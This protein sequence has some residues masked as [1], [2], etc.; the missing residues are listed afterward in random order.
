MA[1]TSQQP[2]MTKKPKQEHNKN[3]ITAVVVA[4]AATV[5]V[6]VLLLVNRVL[7]W[8]K[9]IWYQKIILILILVLI[10]ACIGFVYKG[11]TSWSE[12]TGFGEYTTHRHTENTEFQ[13]GKTLWDWLQLLI[14]PIMLAAVVFLFNYEQDQINS[15]TNALQEQ[16]NAKMADAQH[17][18]DLQI[19]KDQQQ[20][21][22]L[23]GY[24]DHMSD[25]LLMDKLRESKQGDEVRQVAKARTLA[26]LRSL[27]PVRKGILLRFLYEA[28]L[29]YANNPIIDL[30]L[31]DLTNIALDGAQLPN[32]D[33]NGADLNGAQLS[34][35]N[36]SNSDLRNTNFTNAELNN[37]NLNY[38]LLNNAILNNA[39]L[40]EISLIH[41]NL[42]KT[43]LV[44][45]SLDY[46]ILTS[47]TLYRAD[48]FD[49]ILSDANLSQA[50]L[51]YSNL[52]SSHLDYAVLKQAHIGYADL[53]YATLTNAILIGADLNHADLNHT[54]LD[55]ANLSSV[56][57][58]NADVSGAT[59]LCKQINKA[60]SKNGIIG[61]NPKC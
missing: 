2:T 61:I 48:L 37:A 25:L 6:L 55:M 9:F 29:I 11:Y 53:S 38:A 3:L 51:T 12:W 40:S 59:Y 47:A 56:V 36:L 26:A 49:A 21:M 8:D 18:I 13:R 45:A 39:T 60:K 42:S 22:I 30:S 19:A 28:G 10:P 5:S 14:I 43:K 54:N 58:D 33:L 7:Q 1:K 46:A 24:L 4:E 16:N 52:G 35:T 17:K 44:S 31:A 27:D 15:R 34:S 23:E 20:E 41:A 57:L 50:D 32:V